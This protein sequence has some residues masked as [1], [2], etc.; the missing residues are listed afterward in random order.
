M[1][2]FKSRQV[3]MAQQEI[4]FLSLGKCIPAADLI[5]VIVAE[6]QPSSP[7]K[8]MT[9]LNTILLCS[10]LALV[11]NA[12]I[13]RFPEY[14]FQNVRNNHIAPTCHPQVTISIAQF[15]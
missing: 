3:S 12:V 7:S 10:P 9:G 14:S 15:T 4:C 5:S 8:Y 6:L 2:G 11:N 13:I 1:V